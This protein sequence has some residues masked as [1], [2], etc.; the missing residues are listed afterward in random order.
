[1]KNILKTIKEFLELELVSIGNYK[2]MVHTI[3]LILAIF[4]FTKVLLW[5]IRKA[6]NRQQRKNNLDPGNTYAIFQI[7]KY[8]FHLFYLLIFIH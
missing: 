5:L 6:L 3:V 1:M 4:T 8:L 7:I 2:I